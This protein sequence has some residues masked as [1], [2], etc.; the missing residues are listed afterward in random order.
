MLIEQLRNQLSATTN[1]VVAAA[2]AAGLFALTGSACVEQEM[3]CL[4]STA[5][6]AATYTVEEQEGSCEPLAT[7]GISAS[8]HLGEGPDGG[9]GTPETGG[10]SLIP[11]HVRALYNNP[12]DAGIEVELTSEYD[13]SFSPFA[14]AHPDADGICRPVELSDVS[15]EHDGTPPSEDDDDDLAP[16]GRRGE[17]EEEGEGDD[18]GDDPIPANEVTAS[19]DDVEI[20]VTPDIQGVHFTGTLTVEQSAC[21]SITYRVDAV[22]PVVGCSSD[23]DCAVFETIDPNFKARCDEDLHVSWMTAETGTCVLDPSR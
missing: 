23:E 17:E 22:A 10:F 3:Y 19:W 4:I 14:E 15:F 2:A 11:N 8:Y 6:F 16:A 5:H 1:P 20:R 21:G 18:E 7:D 12:I 9:N 13:A